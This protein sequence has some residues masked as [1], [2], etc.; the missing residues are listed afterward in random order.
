MAGGRKISKGREREGLGPLAVSGD[1]KAVV[2]RKRLAGIDAFRFAGFVA[3]TLLHT[4]GGKTYRTVDAS[5]IIDL[6]CRFAVPYFFLTSGYMAG[7]GSAPL[8][9][10]L[11]RSSVRI[12]PIFVAWELFYI[13]IAH[14]P[15][16]ELESFGFI[17]FLV[18]FGYPGYHLWFLP[19]LLEN[20]AIL[21]A[22]IEFC[23]DE[24][25][26]AVGGVFYMVGVAYSEFGER[27]PDIHWEV[28]NGPTFGLLFVIVGY[29]TAKREYVASAGLALSL[30]AFGILSELVE[31]TALYDFGIRG[32]AA[33]INFY[34][35]T[36]PYA[37]GVFLLAVSNRSTGT[38]AS[39]VAGIGVYTLG[40][41][42][43]HL[44]FIW[45]FRAF[46]P[47]TG[48]LNNLLT[49]A[50]SVAASVPAILLIARIPRLRVL[51][52]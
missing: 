23:S 13:V 2:S 48:L 42:C 3:V 32:F 40:Y 7:I 52:R 26:L 51:V 6:L 49:A 29:L 9:S 8:A 14:V 18:V 39:S 45:Y 16:R 46:F 34:L 30:A 1:V 4:V 27:L 35:G 37:V 33:D 25:M 19:S 36:L 22:L 43:I 5:K 20:L 10:R 41:Y 47:D 11:W 31:A 44:A 38:T 21:Y 24:T 50:C 17:K 12:V 15:A 28:R